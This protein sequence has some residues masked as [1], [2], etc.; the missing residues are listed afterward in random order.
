MLV[1]D[2]PER[3]E[4]DALF[5]RLTDALVKHPQGFVHRDYQSRNLMWKDDELVLI[6]FQDA[7]RGPRV[8]DLVALLCDSYVSIDEDLQRAMIKRYAATRALDSEALEAEFWEQAIQRK[9]KDA[10]RF[11]YID[12]VRK[13]PGFLVSFPQ[14]IE[15]V[16]RALSHAPR[17]SAIDAI[18]EKRL[19]GYP[20]AV[21]VPAATS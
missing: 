4:L 6:D 2:I 13:N 12:R 8:Y 21:A 3:H 10:G 5:D 20:D 14:S 15:Y 17:W 7:M 9:L 19:P 18:L 1:G 16:R 11:I